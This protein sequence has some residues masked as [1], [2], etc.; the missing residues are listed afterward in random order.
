MGSLHAYVNDHYTGGFDRSC[1][2]YTPGHRTHWIQA[3][4]CR[5]ED[6]YAPAELFDVEGH[7]LTFTSGGVLH[8]LWH[9]DTANIA[10]A[11]RRITLGAPELS[12]EFSERFHLLTVTSINLEETGDRG[13]GVSGT[14]LCLAQEP[15]ECVTT[16]PTTFDEALTMGGG[17]IMLP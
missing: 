10:R 11:L 13:P 3:R 15:S 4:L 16:T 1:R 12:V 6:T 9:H 5:Q 2:L 7:W 17:T 14:P 8:R